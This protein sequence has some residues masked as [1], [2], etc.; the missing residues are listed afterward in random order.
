MAYGLSNGHVTDD[1]TWPWKIKLVTP[2]RLERT[3][4]QKLLELET[5]NL[6]SS[7]V[8]GMPS[9]RTNDFPWK[10]A[11]PRSRDPYNFGS[12]VGY[13][14]DSLASCLLGQPVMS[15]KTSLAALR[16]YGY[17]C[18]FCFVLLSEN[19][20]DDDDNVT[21]SSISSISIQSKERSSQA[22]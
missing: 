17:F 3:I 12:M 20:Y 11:W 2:I 21:W 15:C 6:V 18:D 5:S 10:W 9:G 16:S 7:F 8:W 4:S 22:N 1:V 14:S 13:T 19:K